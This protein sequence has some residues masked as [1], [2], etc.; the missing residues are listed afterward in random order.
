MTT[1]ERLF[2][3]KDECTPAI[4]NRASEKFR[5]AEALGGTAKP[6]WSPRKGRRLSSFLGASSV[7]IRLV[8]RRKDASIG[9]KW[10]DEFETRSENLTAMEARSSTGL[11][12]VKPRGYA[13][14]SS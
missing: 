2:R 7:A 14:V 12:T 5:L 1:I 8:V 4:R 3:W 11:P 13:E 6:G 9:Q 10:Q